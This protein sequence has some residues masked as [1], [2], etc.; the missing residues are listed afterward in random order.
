MSSERTLR[1][2]QHHRF[3]LP[4]HVQTIMHVEIYKL[5]LVYYKRDEEPMQPHVFPHGDPLAQP[6]PDLPVVTLG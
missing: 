4:I 6:D 2:T 1:L 3:G 5:D